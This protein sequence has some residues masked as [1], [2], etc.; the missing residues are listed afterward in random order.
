MLVSCSGFWRGSPLFRCRGGHLPCGQPF[1]SS[2]K[3]P[4]NAKDSKSGRE[5]DSKEAK[6]KD[7]KDMKAASVFLRLLFA[8][9][10]CAKAVK[11][12][13]PAKD[14]TK[15]KDK[16]DPTRRAESRHALV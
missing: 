6:S 10:C 3:R 8:L 2:G 15:D 9:P 16:A 11:E 4:L 5:K 14:A 1:L 7:V 12:A 13:K